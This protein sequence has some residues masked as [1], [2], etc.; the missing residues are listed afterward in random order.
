MSIEKR[1]QPRLPSALSVH[2]RH[3]RRD[4]SRHRTIQNIS[5]GGIACYSDEA[6][7]T[8]DRITVELG[9]GGQHL[10]LEGCVVWCRAAGGHFELGLRFDEGAGDSREKAYR[11][12]AEI[13]RYRHEVLML[14]GRQLSSDAAAQ[15]WMNARQAAARG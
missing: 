2:I 11:D 14:E 1:V 15:E 8:G 7:P 6:V 10:Q 4:G 9:I 3:S 13:E 12:L 5:L